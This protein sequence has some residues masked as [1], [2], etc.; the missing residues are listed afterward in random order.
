MIVVLL[1]FLLF[2]KWRSCP[3]DSRSLFGIYLIFLK[4]AAYIEIKFAIHDDY[5]YFCPN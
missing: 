1:G 5:S 4:F 3:D 2:L